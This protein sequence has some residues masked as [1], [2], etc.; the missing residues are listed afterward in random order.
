MAPD[1]PSV[2]RWLD[3][4]RHNDERAAAQLWRRFL[5]RLLA[6]ARR[7]LAGAARRVADEEDVV[8]VAFERFLRGVRQGRFPRLT[9]RA[10]LW[11]ASRQVLPSYAQWKRARGGEGPWRYLPASAG[12]WRSDGETLDAVEQGEVRVRASEV[13]LEGQPPLLQLSRWARGP[14]TTVEALALPVYRRAK[15]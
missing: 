6:V 11:A 9:D 13:E 3:R 7:R 4:L 8:V 15:G 5:E 12:V 2:S 14:G 10:D 1:S